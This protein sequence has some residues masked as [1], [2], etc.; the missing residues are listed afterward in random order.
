MIVPALLTDSQAEFEKMLELCQKFASYIQV[1]IMD[2]KFVPSKSISADEIGGL[3]CG[4]RSEVHLMVKNPLIWLESLK[5]FGAERIIFHWEAGRDEEERRLIIAEI[6]RQGF[7]VGIAINPDTPLLN[8]FETFSRLVDLV[9]FMSVH[10]G[11]YGAEFLPRVL[12]QIKV[13]KSLHPDILVGI[14][15][16]INFDN[17]SRVARL[18]VGHICV[19]SAIMKAV[20]PQIAFLE[21]E[22]MA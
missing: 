4:M 3:R 6:R 7:E 21:L 11:F 22:E 12:C 1:D 20:N 9:L 16:G 18:G 8:D 17:V 14:D 2:G 15:G 5:L 13:F 10:P 19:G